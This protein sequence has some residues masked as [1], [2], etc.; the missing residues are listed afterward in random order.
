MDVICNL[1]RV[2]YVLGDRKLI[3]KILSDYILTT[4]TDLPKI[5]GFKAKNKNFVKLFNWNETH[6]L[7]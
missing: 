2:I 5:C 7:S 3:V 4:Q 1:M 6:F